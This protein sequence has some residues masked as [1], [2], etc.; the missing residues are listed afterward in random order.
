LLP[1]VINFYTPKEGRWACDIQAAVLKFWIRCDAPEGVEALSRA[2]NARERT[3]CYRGVLMEVLFEDW[4]EAALPVVEHALQDGDPEVLISVVRV[5]EKH[6]DAKW[7]PA[8]IEAME[9]AGTPLPGDG[10]KR[11]EA[12]MLRS[13]AQSLLESQRWKPDDAQKERLR[14]IAAPPAAG[15]AHRF[16]K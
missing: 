9:R 15:E 8:C 13:T 4:N 12:S 6:A 11:G 3:K 1:E 7:I 5:L 14:K 16:P 2:L 10:T